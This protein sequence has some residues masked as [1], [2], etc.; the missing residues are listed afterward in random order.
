M[1]R[2]IST[3][4]CRFAISALPRSGQAMVEFVI[5][6]VGVLLVAAGILLLAEL[7]RADTDTFVEATAEAIDESTSVS[8]ASSFSPVDD[9]QPGRDDLRYTKD[10]RPDAGSFAGVRDRIARHTAPDG[11][12]SGFDR[13][14]GSSARYDDIRQFH[15]GAMASSIFRFHRATSEE[16]VEPL[17]VLRRLLGLPDTMTLRNETWMPS[18]GGLY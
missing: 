8:I 14:D 15:D 5:A 9:W 1:N 2:P 7:H 12:W 13:L 18:T 10:D 16:T 6:L 4:T 3:T 11:D 17:P